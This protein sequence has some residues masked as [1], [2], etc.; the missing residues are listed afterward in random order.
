VDRPTEMGDI[1]SINFTGYIDDEP[2]EGGHAEDFEITLGSKTFIDTF[3]EQLVGRSV[4]DDVDVNVTFPED[5]GK[6]ELQGKSA[7]FKVE[8]LEVQAKELPEID[9][10]FAQDVSEFET[11]AE[12]RE[13]ITE[14]IREDK[15]KEALMSKRTNVLKQLVDKAVM[16]IPEVMYT[17]RVEEMIQ[18]MRY[19]LAGRGLN[20]EQ[21]LQFSGMTLEDLENNYRQPAKEEV[22]ARLVLE[23]ISKKEELEASDDELREHIEKIKGPSQNTD[24]ILAKLDEDRKKDI[25]QD[26]LNQKALDFV[27][28]KAVAM[29]AV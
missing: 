2:F 4:G 20:L 28:D 24:D 7:L 6:E 1:V 19:S 9:D 23:A 14:K 15:E 29:E 12:W 11:L 25:I 3:E 26:I 21:Y 17:A 16:D 8:I 27:A 10:E 22:E 5:Y 18:E 13:S